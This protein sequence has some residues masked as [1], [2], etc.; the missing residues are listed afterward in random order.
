MEVRH[1]SEGNKER[2]ESVQ[3]KD[4]WGQ[5]GRGNNELEETDILAPQWGKRLSEK[6]LV[7]LW[8]LHRAPVVSAPLSSSRA[9]A[10][11]LHLVLVLCRAAAPHLLHQP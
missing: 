4:R 3:K 5:T 8:W 6:G 1:G 11:H 7:G 9:E 2:E 10:T